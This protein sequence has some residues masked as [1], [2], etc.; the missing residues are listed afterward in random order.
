M[1]TPRPV[2]LYQEFSTVG[3]KEPEKVLDQE[4]SALAA[5][6]QSDG[7]GYMETY[8]KNIEE[9]LDIMVR[10]TIETGAT[11]EEIGNRTVVKEIT[12]DVL[13]R[14][15]EYVTDARESAGL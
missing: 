15:R 12:K 11:N 4:T 3:E 2:S 8:I 7:W 6:S 1:N 9:E 14:I 13:R 5:L 10:K